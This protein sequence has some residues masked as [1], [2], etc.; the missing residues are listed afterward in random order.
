MKTL[1]RA[2]PLD[3]NRIKRITV[4]EYGQ[5]NLYIYKPSEQTAE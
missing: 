5:Y 3:E 2:L 4:G 1:V